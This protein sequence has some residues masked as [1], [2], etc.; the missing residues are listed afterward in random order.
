MESESF[1]I[2]VNTLVKAA[3]ERLLKKGK[4]FIAAE[5]HCRKVRRI[6]PCIEYS[7]KI[8]DL[9]NNILYS[10]ELVQELF[11]NGDAELDSFFMQLINFL[12]DY[13]S[14]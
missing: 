5:Y 8:T 3:N 7:V 1:N 13:T 12:Y 10:K 9:Q 11:R 6:V 4:L 2:F 14:D